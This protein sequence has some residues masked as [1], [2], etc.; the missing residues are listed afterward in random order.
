MTC[1]RDLAFRLK[2]LE[3][4]DQLINQLKALQSGLEKQARAL[5]D[6]INQDKNK[7]KHY[8]PVMEEAG[9]AVLKLHRAAWHAYMSTLGDLCVLFMGCVLC[10]TGCLTQNNKQVFSYSP[11]RSRISTNLPRTRLSWAKLCCAQP[12]RQTR[13]LRRRP[14]S[15]TMARGLLRRTVEKGRN[16]PELDFSFGI[17][18]R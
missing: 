2:P 11:C 8:T 3:M 14:K 18:N 6:L 5:Q 12:K 4:S 16:L 13:V 17:M 15:R 10:S 9:T 1:C 7:M